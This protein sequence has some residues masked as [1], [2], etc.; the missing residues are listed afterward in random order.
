MSEWS[1]EWSPWLALLSFALGVHTGLALQPTRPASRSTLRVLP[2][3]WRRR[4]LACSSCARTQRLASKTRS[5][6]ER[7]PWS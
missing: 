2:L 7:A 3:A 5:T 1:L 4:M 6:P